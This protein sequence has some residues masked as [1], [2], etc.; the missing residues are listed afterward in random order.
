MEEREIYK[1]GWGGARIAGPGKKLG[2][3]T[4]KTRIAMTFKL[5]EELADKLREEKNQTGLIVKLL[6]EH[7][8]ITES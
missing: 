4:G 6:S 1:A 5:P 3:P 8:R 7:Y 2:R